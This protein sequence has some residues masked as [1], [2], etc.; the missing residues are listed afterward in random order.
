MAQVFNPGEPV[1]DQDTGDVV[2]DPTTGDAVIVAPGEI[3]AD[4][5]TGTSYQ[6]DDVAN[7]A[8]WR[9]N[10]YTGEVLRDQSKGVDYHNVVFAVP[11][12]EDLVIAEIRGA[13]M[14][15]P[16]IAAL[17][18]ARLVS[19]DPAS[20]SVYFVF[21]ANKKDSTAVLVGIAGQ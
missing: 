4:P 17:T 20:R 3:W 13:I 2:I 6:R 12:V 8:Y 10:T 7:A 18:E 1:F 9:V 14:D 16:G 15:T 5:V 21:R 19:Y 11:F